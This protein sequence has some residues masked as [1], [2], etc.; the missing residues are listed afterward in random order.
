VVPELHTDGL[1]E[2]ADR[3][4]NLPLLRGALYM[5]GF[6]CAFWAFVAAFWSTAAF[7]VLVTVGMVAWMVAGYID[8]QED[9]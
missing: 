6:G 4:L 5:A 1:H 2:N 3:V 7:A 9:Q 8:Y